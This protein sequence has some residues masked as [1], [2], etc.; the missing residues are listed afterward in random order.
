MLLKLG[1][2]LFETGFLKIV[3]LGTLTTNND[4]KNRPISAHKVSKEF[5]S[6]MQATNWCWIK[7]IK[8]ILWFWN[9]AFIITILQG[10]LKGVIKLLHLL[11]LV[12]TN[13]F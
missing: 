13:R 10:V 6:I 12:F 7:I 11:L 4:G 1:A 3:S 2:I 5:K 8:L 9:S